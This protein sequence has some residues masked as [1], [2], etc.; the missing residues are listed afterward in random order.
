MKPILSGV[1]WPQLM[2][3]MRAETKNR[4][5]FQPLV[6]LYR[7]WAR[8]PHS[9]I[10]AILDSATPSLDSAA[11][12]ADPFSGGGTV[13]IEAIRRS[14][15]VYAQD[16]NPWASWGL[17]VS[18]TA[19]DP[20]ALAVAGE[21][22]LSNLRRRYGA[23]YEP[24]CGDSHCHVHT[25]RVRTHRCTDCGKPVWLFPYPLISVATR[26]HGE[27]SG[28][29]GCRACGAVTKHALESDRWRCA[30]CGVDCG[31]CAP[32]ECPHCAG[33]ISNGSDRQC[34]A[35]SVVLLQR[36]M[37]EAGKPR[38]EFCLPSAQDLALAS[39]IPL[40]EVPRSLLKVI[41][42]GPETAKL[43]RFGFTTWADLYPRRQLSVLLSATRELAAM[44]MDD[45]IRDRL[46]L[47]LAGATEMPGHICRWDRFHP[48]IFEGLANHRYSFD[49]LAVEPYLLSVVG[50]GT[51][52]HR[53]ASS[54]TAARWLAHRIS[55]KSSV[56]YLKNCRQRIVFNGK[57]IAAVVLG[58][59][60]RLL[61]KDR[62]VSLIVTDPPY[63]DS[64]HYGEL[65]SLFLA[66]T[67]ALGI[68]VRAGRF[69][70]RREAVP[71]GRSPLCEV[72]YRK[73]LTRVFREC[74]RVLKNNGRLILTYHSR[75]LRAWSALGRALASG[76]FSI[77]ALAAAETENGLDHAKRGKNSF[78]TD[79][80]IECVRGRTR[81]P[82]SFK[83]RPRTPEQ[84]EL[85]HI[86]LAM[87][88]VRDGSY[89]EL[90]TVFLRRVARMRQR[91]ISAPDVG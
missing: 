7:W 25:F 28:F 36:R 5:C 27:K 68:A 45:G 89:L 16:V 9:L 2:G 55:P 64:V 42:T 20:D 1:R 48:K 82:V 19:V 30:V 84:R 61:L 10:G 59:S 15:S 13:A 4:E 32:D 43:L 21:L 73:K 51:L 35:W 74:S 66:W 81:R 88:A 46:M 6:S 23:L 47:C 54:V 3:E 80:L 49:G 62:T 67:P 29:F 72:D 86:G 26:S 39:N 22:F 75:N 69:E 44:E 79:L 14:L 53:I 41:P 33:I 34:G 50:R 83:T 56:T 8:R 38:L 63:Y 87:A 37:E 58:S 18:L 40:P 76:G 70:S 12:I 57:Q 78:V 77:V 17:R 91:K 85:L 90:R 24:A 71:H 65:A 52:A 31:L 11:L 60:E